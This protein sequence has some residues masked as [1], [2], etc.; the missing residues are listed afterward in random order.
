MPTPSGWISG[1]ASK[2]TQEMPAWWQLSASVSPPMPPPTISTSGEEGLTWGSLRRDPAACDH[3]GPA[4]AVLDHDLLQGVGRRGR[5]HQALRLEDGPGVGA[6]Q[7][8]G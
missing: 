8:G 7:D 1:A 6:A 2:T 5:G 3:V 4:L